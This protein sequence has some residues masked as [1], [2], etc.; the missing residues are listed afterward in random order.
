MS[1]SRRE[2]GGDAVEDAEVVRLLA[3]IPAGLERRRDRL[4]DPLQHR[5]RA[6]RQIVVEQHHARVEIGERDAP[7]VAQHRLEQQRVLAGESTD[8]GSV[9]PGISEPMRTRM[10]ACARMRTSVATFCR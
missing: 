4:V 2:I 10:P 1:S 3:V 7:S 8:S 5:R 6:G 9:R